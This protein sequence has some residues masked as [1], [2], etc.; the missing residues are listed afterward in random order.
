MSN[1]GDSTKRTGGTSVYTFATVVL[2]LVMMVGLV[3]L[4]DRGNTAAAVLLGVIGG[5]ILI[6][7]GVLITLAANWAAAKREQASFVANAR[8]NLAM[9]QQMQKAQNL[10]NA[11][12]LKQARETQRMLP[13]SVE[14][15]TDIDA[16]VFEDGVFEELEG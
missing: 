15:P 4:T 8:E 11:M 1:Q 14:E 6:S 7:L 10:Q 2:L 5:A 16:L 12:L 3:W 13:G 9:M